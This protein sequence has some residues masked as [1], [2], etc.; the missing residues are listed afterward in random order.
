MDQEE[1]YFESEE[2]ERGSPNTVVPPA[3]DEVAAQ[4]VEGELHRTTR[5]FSLA[6]A[7]LMNNGQRRVENTD[8]NQE[9]NHGTID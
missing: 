5:M 8:P 7:P 2:D 9:T 6:Q 1:S 4:E 3:V